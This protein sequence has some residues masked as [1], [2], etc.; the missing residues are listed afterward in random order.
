LPQDPAVAAREFKSFVEALKSPDQ[1]RRLYVIVSSRR[2]QLPDFRQFP[3]LEELTLHGKLEHV[4]KFPEIFDCTRLR[5]LTITGTS[6]S[7][8]PSGFA[9]LQQLVEL[10]LVGHPKL[11]SLPDDVVELR[12]LEYLAI[13]H[14]RL[15]RLPDGIGKLQRLDSLLAYNNA[16]RELPTSLYRMTK[17]R[18]LELQCNRLIK[19]PTKLLRMKLRHLM[20]DF[21]EVSR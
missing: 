19:P 18:W 1:V 7:K 17:L 11:T 21:D 4:T 13:D 5:T 14:N 2:T 10:K 6:I 15:R 8:I 12:K 3:A 20:T 9:K 16:I